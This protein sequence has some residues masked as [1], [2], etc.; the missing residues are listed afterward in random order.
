MSHNQGVFTMARIHSFR[1]DMV[2]KAKA[3]NKASTGKNTLGDDVASDW[4][5]NSKK[6]Q[7]EVAN[8]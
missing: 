5:F 4:A 8:E 6:S 3:P 2:H 7:M 1:R